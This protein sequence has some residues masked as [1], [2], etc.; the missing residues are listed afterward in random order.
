M[1]LVFGK[2]DKKCGLLTCIRDDGSQTSSV[3]PEHG[4]L[5]HDLIHYVVEKHFKMDGAFYAQVKAGA[6]INFSLEHNQA[7]RSV[8]DK[9]Q[10]WQTE[11]LVEALQ[12]LM[13]SGNY[14]YTD[15]SYLVEQ[16]CQ[17]RKIPLPTDM[18]E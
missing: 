8:G 17:A 11:S 6:N 7:S 4:I 16:A 13:W 15:F 1:K 3:L 18:S 10:S 14:S 12:A 2:G 9:L 5:P